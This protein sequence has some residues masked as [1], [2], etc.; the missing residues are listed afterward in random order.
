MAMS[1][2]SVVVY[3]KEKLCVRFMANP[4]ADEMMSC[5]RYMAIDIVQ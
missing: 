4:T 3:L 5:M 2:N 1:H